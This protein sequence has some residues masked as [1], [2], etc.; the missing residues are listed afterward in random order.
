MNEMTEGTA[1]VTSL[2]THDEK[3]LA[4]G[5]A[6]GAVRIFAIDSKLST[7]VLR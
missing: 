6:D 3:S 4:V 2:A 1:T 5:Y 7:V